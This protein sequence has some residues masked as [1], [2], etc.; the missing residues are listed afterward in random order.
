MPAPQCPAV[1]ARPAFEM[2]H[3]VIDHQNRK[4]TPKFNMLGGFPGISVQTYFSSALC[5]STSEYKKIT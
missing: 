1:N 5:G 4:T 2:Q 3:L